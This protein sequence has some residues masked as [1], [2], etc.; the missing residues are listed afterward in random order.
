MSAR[1]TVLD[2]VNQMLSCIGGAAVV[3]LDTDNP[4]VFTA[5]SI[6]EETTRNVL[7]EGW[8]FNT[9]LEYPF[10]KQQNGEIGVPDNLIS[11]TLSFYK[12]AADRDLIVER[13]K[14]FY[15]KKDHTYKFT[16]TICAD[17][18]WYFPFEECP[19]PIKEY[20]T[21]RASR[22]YASRLVTSEEQVQL[23]AQDEAA[24]RTICIEYDTQTAKAN[25]FGLHDGTNNYISYQPYRSLLR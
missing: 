19:Q 8:N 15:N 5:Q 2:A 23:I 9:E 13:G 24:T 25:V 14:K 3:N 18:V 17:V 7:A 11:F 4:E 16:E 22:I 10:P 20:I 1:T 6:L 12:H 21:A